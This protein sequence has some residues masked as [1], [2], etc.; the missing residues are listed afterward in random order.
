MGRGSGGAG[1]LL[2]IGGA[3]DKTGTRRPRRFVERAG[4]SAARIAVVATASS[5]G[6]EIVDAYRALFAR[7]VP[8]TCAASPPAAPEA[9]DPAHVA[10]IDG[11]TGV[12]MTGGDQPKLSGVITGTPFGAPSSTPALRAVPWV[13]PPRGPR[14]SASTWSRSGPGGSTPKHRMAQMPAAWDW[15]RPRDRPALRPAK[16]LRPVADLVAQAPHLLGMGVD[17][18]TAADLPVRDRDDAEGLGRGSVTLLDGRLVTDADAARGCPR[19][20][21]PGWCCTRCRRGPPST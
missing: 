10:D 8:P 11:A 20:W 1:D 13:G 19:C 4:G 12:F 21:P 14:S 15:C 6:P 18:D 5:L 9:A 7:L 2:V 3:E 16:P 17:E